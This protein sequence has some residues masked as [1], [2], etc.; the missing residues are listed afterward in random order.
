MALELD[1]TYTFD[2]SR[3]DVERVFDRVV[4]DSL[5]VA[6]AGEWAVALVRFDKPDDR[7]DLAFRQSIREEDGF[8]ELVLFAASGVGS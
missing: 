8:S 5:G 7:P 2:V 3:A 1:G 6:D 4:A